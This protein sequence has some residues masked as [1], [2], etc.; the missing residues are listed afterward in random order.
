MTKIAVGF[1]DEGV[2]C[3]GEW[4]G[5]VAAF[6]DSMRHWKWFATLENA[7][8]D[9]GENTQIELGS[10]CSKYGTP[11]IYVVPKEHVEFVDA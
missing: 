11:Q 9:T 10:V 8:W 7:N 2:R 3:F 1:N 6:P 5:R 4:I